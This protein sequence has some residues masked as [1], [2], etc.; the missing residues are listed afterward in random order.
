L[1]GPGDGSPSEPIEQPSDRA[2]NSQG[3]VALK[4][5]EQTVCDETVDVGRAYFKHRAS[6]PTLTAVPE[7]RHTNSPVSCAGL[8]LYRRSERLLAVV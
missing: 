4:S 5:I 8:T 7:T 3:I 1:A 2:I 6:I